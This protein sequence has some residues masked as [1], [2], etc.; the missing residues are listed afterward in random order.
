MKALWSDKQSCSYNVSQ[1]LKFMRF[2][3]GTNQRCI[4][5]SLGGFHLQFEPASATCRSAENNM[6][7]GTSCSE[8]KGN[9]LVE[10]PYIDATYAQCAWHQLHRIEGPKLLG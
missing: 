3:C 4:N 7:I 10:S 2:L 1:T 6:R 5:D 9:I 8:K